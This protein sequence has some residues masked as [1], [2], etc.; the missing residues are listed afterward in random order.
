MSSKSGAPLTVHQQPQTF[1]AS[2]MIGFP[3]D[4]VRGV[5]ESVVGEQTRMMSTVAEWSNGL[6]AKEGMKRWK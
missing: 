5:C 4:A 1:S 2:L 3:L 6:H